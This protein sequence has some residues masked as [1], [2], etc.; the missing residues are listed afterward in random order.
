MTALPSERKKMPSTKAS[1][2]KSLNEA[3]RRGGGIVAFAR[4][5]GISHQAV[6]RWRQIGYVP[7]DKALTI[8]QLF[9]VPRRAV[10]HPDML[11]LLDTPEAG[12]ESIV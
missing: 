10:V 4:K 1:R 8:E 11:L 5:L 3:I 12:G 2:T 7:P 6:T 9:G